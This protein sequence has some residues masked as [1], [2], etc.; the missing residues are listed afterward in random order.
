VKNVKVLRNTK[1]LLIIAVII[2]AAV[3]GVYFLWPRPKTPLI[4]STTT[5][6]YETGFLT[7]LKQNFEQTNPGFNVSFISQGTGQAL[8]TAQ[9]G[10][11][12][13]VL[14]HAPS[15]ELTFMNNS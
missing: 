3:V 13:L 14:V 10:G 6:L 8:L 2:V 7:V 15:N 5:S 12:D 4:V 9:N 11:A 1:V